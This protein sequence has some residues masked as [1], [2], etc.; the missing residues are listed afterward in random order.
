MKDEQ[1]D[2][3]ASQAINLAQKIRR[4]ARRDGFVAKKSRRDGKWY[5]ADHR[6]LLVSPESGLDDEE[7]LEFLM[8]D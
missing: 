6:N 7:A 2:K 3:G 5:F 1:A 8:S 4:S